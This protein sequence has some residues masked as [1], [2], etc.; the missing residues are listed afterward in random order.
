[1]TRHV[2][3]LNAGSSSIKFALFVTAGEDLSAL[4]IG[5]GGNAGRAAPDRGSRWHGQAWP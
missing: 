3:T 5:L 4:A 2:V 1:M